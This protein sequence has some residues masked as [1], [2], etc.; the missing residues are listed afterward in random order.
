M[1]SMSAAQKTARHLQKAA[2]FA[3]TAQRP[4]TSLQLRTISGQYPKK[5]V[6]HLEALTQFNFPQH[7]CFVLSVY[8]VLTTE[9]S[10]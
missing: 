1:Q 7:S 8:G 2:L 4:K 9:L 5:S 6:I 10:I 3:S